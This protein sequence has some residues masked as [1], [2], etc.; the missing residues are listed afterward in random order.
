MKVLIVKPVEKAVAGRVG[1]GLK[2][3]QKFVGG[4]IEMV[5]PFDDNV[6]LVCNE[7]G[8]ING[9]PFNRAIYGDDGEIADFIVGDFFICDTSGEDVD[10]L[11]DDMMK[12]YR[13]MF[14]FPEVMATDVYNNGDVVIIKQ[15]PDNLPPTTKL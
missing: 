8:K 4:S 11:S 12:K 13:K 1:R 5:Y 2:A 14:E 3:M 10:S 9:L 7:E 15:D 6:S